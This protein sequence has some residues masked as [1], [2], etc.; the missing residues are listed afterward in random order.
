M[1]IYFLS[2]KLYIFTYDTL[3]FQSPSFT[4][5]I[6]TINKRPKTNANTITVLYVKPERRASYVLEFMAAFLYMERQPANMTPAVQLSKK[7]VLTLR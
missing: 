7:G 2:L 4:F 6:S 1:I 5:P 3:P